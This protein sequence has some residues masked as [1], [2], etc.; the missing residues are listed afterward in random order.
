LR[1]LL[2]QPNLGTELK[3]LGVE[4]AGLTSCMAGAVAGRV[5]QMTKTANALQIT[6]TPAFLIGLP[7]GTASVRVKHRLDGA[8]SSTSMGTVIDKLV[9]ESALVK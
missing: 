6:G 2:R 7:E 9:K 8:V 3:R 5:D 4:Q 1:E